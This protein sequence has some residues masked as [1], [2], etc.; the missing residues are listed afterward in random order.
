M[1]VV[2]YQTVVSYPNSF[3]GSTHIHCSLINLVS[4][5]HQLPPHPL[6]ISVYSVHDS[7]RVLTA[8]VLIA[9][10][11]ER[12]CTQTPWIFSFFVGTLLAF[13][14]ILEHKSYCWL[15]LLFFFIAE[16]LVWVLVFLC[17]PCQYEY[18]IM[19]LK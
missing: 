10:W 9:D 3:M 18:Q 4:I 11:T 6:S 15:R 19:D 7:L 2:S 14:H 12:I 13:L 1:P 5:G 16:M 17:I 8:V